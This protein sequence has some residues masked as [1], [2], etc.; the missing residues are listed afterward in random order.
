LHSKREAEKNVIEGRLPPVKNVR[1][2]RLNVYFA[3]TN[4]SLGSFGGAEKN[5]LRCERADPTVW[6]NTNVPGLLLLP[7]FVPVA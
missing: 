7:V 3:K 2:D 4:L 5:S 6:S 1:I